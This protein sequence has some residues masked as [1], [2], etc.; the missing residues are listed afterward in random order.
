MDAW[1]GFYAGLNVGGD[2][3]DNNS[4]NTVATPT[5]ISPTF[6][7]GA[8]AEA[9]ALAAAAT[10]SQGVRN[11][12]FI[13]GG[14]IGYNYQFNRWVAGVEADIEGLASSSNSANL[15]RFVVLAPPFVAE[16][17][18]GTV[19]VAKTLNWLGTVRGRVGVLATPQLL[20]YGTGGFA[21]G[22]V[23]TASSYSFQESL[24]GGL[25]PVL[26]TSGTSTTRTGWT[27]GAGGEWMFASNWTAR[28]EYLHYD[29]GSVTDSVTL[30]Q[31]LVGVPYH[32][33]LAQTFT[34]FSGDIVRV[35][36]NYKFGG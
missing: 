34:R 7:A 18:T 21:Y 6:L 26:G 12:G 23:S 11:S 32:T 30:T 17:Y 19:T 13:G 9:N 36:V 16:N 35:G 25:A 15:S 27:A 1:T 4:I 24:G 33:E 20:L 28:L 14:Q 3:S 31:L 10:T 2:W 22:G 5:F 8:G 29:L